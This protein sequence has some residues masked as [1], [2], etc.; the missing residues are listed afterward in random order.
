MEHPTT[1]LPGEKASVIRR[2]QR[3]RQQRV[4]SHG[5]IPCGPLAASPRPKGRGWPARRRGARALTDDSA[6]LFVAGVDRGEIPRSI[7]QD[8][9]GF[10]AAQPALEKNQ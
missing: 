1:Q 3:P 6:M 5:G 8:G 2:E 7:D 4:H 9:V 10:F